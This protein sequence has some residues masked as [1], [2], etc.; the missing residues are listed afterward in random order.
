MIPRGQSLPLFLLQKSRHKR[1]WLGLALWN[2]KWDFNLSTIGFFFFFLLQIWFLWK[3]GINTTDPDLMQINPCL[4]F[5]TEAFNPCYTLQPDD[6]CYFILWHLFSGGRRQICQRYCSDRNTSSRRYAGR[7][8]QE[9]RR[10]EL[11]GWGCEKGLGRARLWS[12]KLG[13]QWKNSWLQHHPD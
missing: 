13:T 10:G 6:C 11:V 4:H 7:R 5:P 2:S 8:A 12:L 9:E 3:W 1:V